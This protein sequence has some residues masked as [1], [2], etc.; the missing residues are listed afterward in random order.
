[1]NVTRVLFGA[2]MFVFALSAFI[3]TFNSGRL[4]YN[5]TDSENNS[6]TGKLNYTQCQQ[7]GLNWCIKC[8]PEFWR[9]FLASGFFGLLVWGI[10]F[11]IYIS[12]QK[13]KKREMSELKAFL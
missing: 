6:S 12:A 2:G 1:V 10:A 3:M 7:A 9:L 13:A 4:L 11:G 5:S 8:K